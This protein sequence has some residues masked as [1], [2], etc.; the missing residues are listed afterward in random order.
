MDRL[1]R[2]LNVTPPLGLGTSSACLD[3]VKGSKARTIFL[4]RYF[5]SGF[6]RGFSMKKS[7][8]PISIIAETPPNKKLP[9]QVTRFMISL[10]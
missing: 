8:S 5:S 3:S 1:F 9:A 7:N 6:F 4:R 2:A 10:L